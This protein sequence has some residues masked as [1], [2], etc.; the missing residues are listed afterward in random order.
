MFCLNILYKYSHCLKV[1]KLANVSRS[2]Q[3]RVWNLKANRWSLSFHL[4]SNIQ[5]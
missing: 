3:I 1:A 4:G 5:Q 2:L